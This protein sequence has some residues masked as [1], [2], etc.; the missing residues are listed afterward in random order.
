M[1]SI[2]IV[3]QEFI[4]IMYWIKYHISYFMCPI[5]RAPSLFNHV[6]PGIISS[7]Y[8]KCHERANAKY[9]VQILSVCVKYLKSYY[10]SMYFVHM[11]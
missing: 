10:Q 5:N 8:A 1:P 7:I 6:M 9:K 3:F 2:Y 11:L 4:H